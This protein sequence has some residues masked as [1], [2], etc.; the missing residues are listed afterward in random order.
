MA[1]NVIFHVGTKVTSVKVTPLFMETNTR[2]RKCQSSCG[3][4]SATLLSQKVTSATF[5]HRLILV[6][7]SWSSHA[8]DTF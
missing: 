7:F 5:D 2:K 3:M 6:L 4:L 8:C 1:L